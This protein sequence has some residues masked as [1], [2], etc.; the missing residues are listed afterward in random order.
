MIQISQKCKKNSQLHSFSR[1]NLKNLEKKINPINYY[2]YSKFLGEK[3]ASK[4][5]KS[6]ILSNA[7]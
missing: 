6:T 3:E 4:F 1:S 2:A 7:R 5:K